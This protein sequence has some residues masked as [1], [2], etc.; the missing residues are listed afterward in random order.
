M[1]TDDQGRLTKWKPGLTTGHSVCNACGK[2]MPHVWDVVCARCHGTF[3]YEH[4]RAY[5]GHWVCLDC[6]RWW[7]KLLGH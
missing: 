5:R 2:D 4:A 7:E 1:A 6:L 3:C